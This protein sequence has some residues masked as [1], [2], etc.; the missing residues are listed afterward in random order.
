M[1]RLA[2]EEKEEKLREEA[3]Q[4]LNNEIDE[5]K[6][7]KQMSQSLQRKTES[8]TFYEGGLL[9]LEKCLQANPSWVVVFLEITNNFQLEAD[10]PISKKFTRQTKCAI[11]SA[12]WRLIRKGILVFLL[13]VSTFFVPRFFHFSE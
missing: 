7:L 1:A 12:C 10:H 5:I 6:D 3:K 13:I 9:L 4:L 8:A 11:N 2:E